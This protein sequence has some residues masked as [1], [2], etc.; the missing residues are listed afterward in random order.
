[1]TM[2]QWTPKAGEAPPIN[3]RFKSRIPALIESIC[4]SIQNTEEHLKEAKVTVQ[5]IQDYL[6][7]EI[8]KATLDV[9]QLEWA[10][11]SD[12]EELD[13]ARKWLEHL[14]DL[15]ERFAAQKVMGSALFLRELREA[16]DENF[17]IKI[18]EEDAELTE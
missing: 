5:E 16:L 18:P 12:Q 1:M 9:E 14:M 6:K 3:P 17:T 10:S 4:W 11:Q 13:R 7:F 8:N 2:T 15:Q